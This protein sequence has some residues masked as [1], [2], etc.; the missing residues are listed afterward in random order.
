[1]EWMT[2]IS[3]YIVVA[4]V[5]AWFGFISG[6]LYSNNENKKIID[7]YQELVDQAI[8]LLGDDEVKK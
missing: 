7:D 1:M 5:F 3:S 6:M 2:V 4:G 8:D